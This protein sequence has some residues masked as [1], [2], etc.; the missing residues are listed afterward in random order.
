MIYSLRGFCSAIL[1]MPGNHLY[2]QDGSFMKRLLLVLLF[3]AFA[4]AAWG[5]ESWVFFHGDKEYFFE[6]PHMGMPLRPLYQ[7][8]TYYY[9]ENSV[10]TSGMLLWKTVSARVKIESWGV[11]NNAESV[12]VWEVDCGKNTITRSGTDARPESSVN[13]DSAGEASEAFYKAF[14]Y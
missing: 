9:D 3:L 13:I 12:V 6:P 4:S 11:Y 14:C 2:R 5:G 7:R 1:K 10:R 8:E